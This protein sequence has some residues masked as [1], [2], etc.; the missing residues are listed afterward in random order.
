[1]P[2]KLALAAISWVWQKCKEKADLCSL[3]QFSVYNIIWSQVSG[4]VSHLNLAC[5]DGFSFQSR[6]SPHFSPKVHS[7]RGADLLLEADTIPKFTHITVWVNKWWN[8]YLCL[9]SQPVFSPSQPFTDMTWLNSTPATRGIS[10]LIA[11][12]EHWSHGHVKCLIWGNKLVRI[13]TRS[14]TETH[15]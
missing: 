1:M 12:T 5:L 8:M 14:V 13:C 9:F 6:Y 15:A 11:A 7:L 4:A 10:I 3:T 2:K